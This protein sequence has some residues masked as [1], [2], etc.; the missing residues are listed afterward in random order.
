M[1][2]AMLEGTLRRSHRIYDRPAFFRPSPVSR[3]RTG[4]RGSDENEAWASGTH[5][6]AYKDCLG[7]DGRTL[8][9]VSGTTDNSS[10]TE[11][12]A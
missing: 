2:D 3:A 8:A 5:T 10:Q 4:G 12:T 1:D 6:W 9:A 11:Y 7:T